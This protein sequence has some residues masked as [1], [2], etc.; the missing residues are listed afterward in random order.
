MKK[1]G[2]GSHKRTWLEEIDGPFTSERRIWGSALCDPCAGRR[3][4]QDAGA[5]APRP[6]PVRPI[7]GARANPRPRQPRPYPIT[8]LPLRRRGPGATSSGLPASGVATVRPASFLSSSH[9]IRKPP[10]PLHPL[11][12][13]LA[14][15][16]RSVPLHRGPR[17]RPS[18]SPSISQVCRTRGVR[19]RPWLARDGTPQPQTQPPRSRTF[20]GPWLSS[21]TDSRIG[22]TRPEQ[23]FGHAS[24]SLGGLGRAAEGLGASGNPARHE[25]R[26]CRA[27]HAQYA[28][29]ANDGL[30]LGVACSR[31]VGH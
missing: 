1:P 25:M 23:A 9:R 13:P 20:S 10:D 24:Q 4:E 11:T 6:R 12:N 15:L 27:C 29:L 31:Q 17:R 16:S 3:A 26:R 7:A 5:P 2:S 22:A 14:P 21:R 30:P 19:R 8:R 18:Q 28:R